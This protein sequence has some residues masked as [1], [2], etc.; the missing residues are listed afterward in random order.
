MAECT[1]VYA[2][3]NEPEGEP[4]TV[5]LEQHFHE[6]GVSNEKSLVYASI[7]ACIG[8]VD[9]IRCSLAEDI[10]AMLSEIDEKLMSCTGHLKEMEQ[11]NERG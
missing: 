5:L 2:D 4:D 11:L 8:R 3:A 6:H 1:D 7:S 10:D 9:V